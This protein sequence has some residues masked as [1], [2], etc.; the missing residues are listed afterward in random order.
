M[1]LLPSL[2]LL[3]FEFPIVSQSPSSYGGTE[4][5]L[6]LPVD[7]VATSLR[8]LEHYFAVG[9]TQH[10]ALLLRVVFIVYIICWNLRRG[11]LSR[12]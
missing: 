1:L 9:L 8:A 3:S 2:S 7:Y 12:R 10:H 4:T 11:L 6:R 5:P